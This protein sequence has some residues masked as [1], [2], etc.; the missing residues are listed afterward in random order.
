[1]QRL[2]N[3]QVGIEEGTLRDTGAYSRADI[4]SKGNIINKRAI[5]HV[6]M[7]PVGTSGEGALGFS[8]YL[9]KITS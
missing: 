8:S 7:Q 1:M 4:W 6:E 9:T 5:H 3:H 2:I